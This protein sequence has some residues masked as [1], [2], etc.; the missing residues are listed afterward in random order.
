MERLM[1]LLGLLVL[2]GI[3]FGLSSHRRKINWRLVGVGLAIQF[4]LGLLL[5]KWEATAA[6]FRW[7]SD[8]VTEFLA[9]ADVGAEFLFGELTNTDSL[10]FIFAVKVVPTIVFFSSFI[11]ICYYLGLVQ[12]VISAIAFVMRRLMGTSGAETLS[13]AGNI[14]VGQTEAPLMIRPYIGAMTFSELNAVMVGGFATIAGGVLA[15]YIGMG[16]SANHLIIASVM[17]APAALVIA[18]L[19]V[20]EIEEPKTLGGAKL[21]D[22]DVGDNLLDAAARGATDGMRLAINVAA[23]LIAFIALIAAVDWVL[24]GLDGLV[25]GRWLGGEPIQTGD[26]TEHRG[27]MPGSLATLFGKL[28]APIAFVMGVAWEDAAKVG[29]LLGAKICVTEF[30]AYARLTDLVGSGELSE[31]S[32]TIATFALCGFANFGSIGIQLGGLGAIAPERR[33]DLARLALRAMFGGAL[34]SWTTAA[35]AGL[36]L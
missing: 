2:L 27:V 20:P 33:R 14:F 11:S 16:V 13:C 15:A 8:R 24:G 36:L 25:D 19:M 26:G 22:I 6:P 23:M 32:V 1:S 31:R 21:P 35:I 34:A 9:A 4:A 10:G 18:K 3:A 17:S 30:I 5:L 29:N 28:F 7:F 12:R